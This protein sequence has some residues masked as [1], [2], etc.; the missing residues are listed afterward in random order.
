MV[1][2]VVLLF[3]RRGR[4]FRYRFTTTNLIG[5]L[6]RMNLMFQC[7]TGWKESRVKKTKKGKCRRERKDSI[8]L[9]RV[10]SRSIPSSV[11]WIFGM[12]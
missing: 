8:I 1:I 12:I 6:G 10:V 11:K 3:L 4:S 7:M 5:R 2:T 9:Q